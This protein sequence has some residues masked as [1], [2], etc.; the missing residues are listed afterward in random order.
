MKINKIIVIDDEPEIVEIFSVFLDSRGFEVDSFTSGEDGLEALKK[1]NYDL[2]LTD[3]KMPFVSGMEII[4]YVEEYSPDSI[5]FM[6]TGDEGTTVLFK[7]KKSQVLIKPIGL[8]D[9]GV[10]IDKL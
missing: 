2:V 9:L 5:I 1:S 10:E 4:E 6:I 3:K 8:I 7:N